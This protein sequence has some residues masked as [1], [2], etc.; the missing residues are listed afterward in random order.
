MKTNGLVCAGLLAAGAFAHK[1]PAL[2]PDR[3]ERD[4]RQ[5]ESVNAISP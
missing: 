4:I 1:G 2:T 5:R 3:I